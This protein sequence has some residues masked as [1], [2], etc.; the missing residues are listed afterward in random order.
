MENFVIDVSNATKRSTIHDI[1]T[2]NLPFPE[3]YGRNLDALY[4]CLSTIFI[5]KEAEVLLVGFS[6]LPEDIFKYGQKI[7]KIFKLTASELS[8]SDNSKLI[9]REFDALIE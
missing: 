1:L 6:K 3:Y 4:D 5:G 2:E 9:V 7:I 8:D